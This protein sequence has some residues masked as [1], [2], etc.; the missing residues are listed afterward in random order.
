MHSYC[1]MYGIAR[2]N[3]TQQAGRAQPGPTYNGP[4]IIIIFQYCTTSN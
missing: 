3:R 4:I 1:G 2:L